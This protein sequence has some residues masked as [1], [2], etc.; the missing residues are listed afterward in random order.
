[1]PIAKTNGVELYYEDE[2]EGEPLVLI[3]GL[4]AQCSWWSPGL[5]RTLRSKGFRIIRFDNRDIGRSTRLEALGRP[6]VRRMTARA[7][8]GGKIKPPYRL[9]DLAEDTVGLMDFL[10]LDRAHVLGASMGGM[11]AQRIALDHASRVRSL[12]LLFTSSGSR[13]DG[14]P[15]PK[16]MRL[17]SRPTPTTKDETIERFAFVG[18]VLTGRGYPYNETYWR[19]LGAECF[20]RS[21][22]PPGTVRQ[23]AA[24]LGSGSTR[25][26]LHKIEQPTLVIHGT[27]DLLVRPRAGLNLARAIPRARML[28][29]QGLGHHL[30]TPVYE[31]VARNIRALADDAAQASPT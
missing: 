2:G 14:L 24:V 1:M 8:L 6:N 25:E 20:D 3:M 4:S 27:D 23:L 29:F 5:L 22:G 28:L 26:R 19:E 21:I 13:R 18:R 11:V 31:T 16:A 30:M 9:E 15:A 10:G 7:L 17:L 12:T